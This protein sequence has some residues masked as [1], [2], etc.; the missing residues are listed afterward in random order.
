MQ[1]ADLKKVEAMIEESKQE[2]VPQDTSGESAFQDSAQ[3]LK[4]EQLAE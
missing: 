4:D 3:P 1:R 2:E